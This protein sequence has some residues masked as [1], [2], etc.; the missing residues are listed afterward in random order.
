MEDIE[1]FGVFPLVQI[2]PYL[3]CSGPNFLWRLGVLQPDLQK[4]FQL[5]W[6]IS[7]RYWALAFLVLHLAEDHPDCHS[8]HFF[9][10]G[11]L[12]ASLLLR[13]NTPSPWAVN[14]GV[15]P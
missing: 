10:G 9:A 1:P 7:C 11:G 5:H 3:Y 12:V 2:Q 8:V 6:H 14:L 13:L 15:S 4:P